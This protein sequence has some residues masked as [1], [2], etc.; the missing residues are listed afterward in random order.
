M[1]SLYLNKNVAVE[2]LFDQWYAWTYLIPPATAS[3]NITDRHLRIIDSYI[4]DPDLHASAV[5]NPKMLGGPFIDY[6]G[7]R[8]DE[9]RALREKTCT[10]RAPLIELS[11]AI[12]ELGDLLRSQAKG[13]SLQPLYP[14]VP[15]VLRG[16]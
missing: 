1:E 8:V 7:E 11:A 5:R 14:K 15:E 2:P 4:S 6:N 10:D 13:F 12:S 16:Y 3:R 9:I